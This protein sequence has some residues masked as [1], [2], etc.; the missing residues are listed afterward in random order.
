MASK[1]E[2]IVENIVTQIES[3]PSIKMVTREPKD[4]LELSVRS[5]PHVLV[6]TANEVRENASFSADVRKESELEILLNIVVHGNNRDQQRN[7]AIEAIEQQLDI[8][9][10]RG[11][12]AF[13]SQ[14]SE[15]T[16]RELNEA[17]PYGQAVMLFTIKYYYTKGTP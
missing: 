16:I 3:I 7:N 4:I 1:R 12:H 14:L 10:T 8:D 6:E 17:A 11:G 13:D 2:L 15:V 5:F 9:S